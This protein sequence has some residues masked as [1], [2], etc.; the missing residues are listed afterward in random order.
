MDAS[1]TSKWSSAGIG[2]ASC[3]A[4][5]ASISGA[6][7]SPPRVRPA[8]DGLIFDTADVLYDATLWP[9]LLLRLVH[10]LGVDATYATFSGDWERNYLADV[11]CG[12]RQYDEAFESFLLSAG[13]S[14]AQIDEVEAASRIERQNLEPNA[15]PLPGVLA[16]IAT[17]CEWRLRL[18]AW[19][20]TPRSASGVA[21]RIARL[22][23]ADRFRAVLSSFD[24]EAAQPAPQCYQAAL[25][26]L[27][28]AADRVAYVGH[29]A[30]HL[31][32]AKAAGLRTIAF[33]YQAA[34]EADFFLSS[35]E[36]L[37]PLVR[38][39]KNSGT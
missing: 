36:E 31:A 14:W 25:A 4:S 6:S 12:R 30:L 8:I 17:L 22:G 11:H 9:R 32:G 23:L 27:D 26:A 3:S 35:F 15:R 10:R 37:L 7:S 39:T 28:L 18:V 2:S 33:N 1:G 24:L 20:D 13:L 19:A 29:D 5:D 38:S 21:E 34:A 16:T